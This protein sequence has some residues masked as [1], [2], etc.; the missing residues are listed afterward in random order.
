M[1]T[2]LDIFDFIADENYI[3]FYSFALV[4]KNDYRTSC[5]YSVWHPYWNKETECYDSKCAQCKQIKAGSYPAQMCQW[6]G[7]CVDV[8]EVF[9]GGVSLENKCNRCIEKD[10]TLAKDFK[11]NA[12]MTQKAK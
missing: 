9:G 3:P 4:T 8:Y 10:S 12:E 7:R 2:Q 1:I 5:C 11:V 6:C